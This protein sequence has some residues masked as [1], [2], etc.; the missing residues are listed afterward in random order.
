LGWTTAAAQGFWVEAAVRN[1]MDIVMAG[2]HGH[3]S[4]DN[5]NLTE[6]SSA[7]EAPDYSFFL[8]H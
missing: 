3:T 4:L 7:P 2:G 8:T 5:V 1:R 6:P